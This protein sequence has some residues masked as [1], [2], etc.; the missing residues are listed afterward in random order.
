VRAK[1]LL[2]AGQFSTRF[3]YEQAKGRLTEARRIAQEINAPR[4][5]GWALAGLMHNEFSR[6]NIDAARVYGEQ[7]LRIFQNAGD[8]VGIGMVTY[9]QTLGDSFDRWRN[10][11]LTPEVAKDLMSKLKPMV[12]GAQQLGDRNLL[13]HVLALLGMIA[14]HAGRIDE[15]GAHLSEAVTAYHTLGN[16]AL[17]A[18]TLDH[19]AALAARTNQ[20]AAAIS[21]L[22]ATTTLRQHIGVSATLVEQIVVDE[23]L[24]TARKNL[25]PDRFKDAWAEGTR[26]TREQAVQ[27]AR[28]IIDGTASRL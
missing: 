26:M 2:G 17:L 19:V 28:T 22:G 9:L 1:L 12:A 8:L 20:P 5:E 25:T 13:G 7:S 24:K 23:A 6:L 11:E 16:Q 21:L 27:H 3:D 18:R 15:A 10:N 4:I 14:L